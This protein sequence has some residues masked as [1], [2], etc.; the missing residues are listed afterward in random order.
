[1]GRGRLSD[2][3]GI[4][5]DRDR[6]CLVGVL[7]IVLGRVKRLSHSTGS[8]GSVQREEERVKTVKTRFFS[9]EWLKG[10]FPGFRDL[11]LSAE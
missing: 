1:M 11:P 4:D 6:A 7:V 8:L 9:K 5:R 3:N 2:R 10:S